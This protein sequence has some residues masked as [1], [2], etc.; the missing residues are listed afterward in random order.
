MILYSTHNE[1]T[2]TQVSLHI[3]T[4][5]SI[6]LQPIAGELDKRSVSK[7]CPSG[8]KSQERFSL[9][10]TQSSD[11]LTS[12]YCSTLMLLVL[13]SSSSAALVTFSHIWLIYFNLDETLHFSSA[14]PYKSVD[15]HSNP[16]TNRRQIDFANVIATQITF[17]ASIQSNLRCMKSFF[18]M[19]YI[20][21]GWGLA[22]CESHIQAI[23]HWSLQTEILVFI[24]MLKNLPCLKHRS[25][26]R[27]KKSISDQTV[28]EGK[29][30]L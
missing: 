11:L 15:C 14:F 23:F 29:L 18:W 4:T 2:L 24:Q 22:G 30:N 5:V 6:F 20:T 17:A 25:R 27:K 28:I 7:N 12:H 1:T 10:I 8:S 21:L 9:F 19:P 16:I 26:L 13:P 3:V